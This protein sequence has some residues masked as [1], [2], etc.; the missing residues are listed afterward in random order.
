M[1][2]LSCAVLFAAGVALAGA[3]GGQA[4]TVSTS[5]E[6]ADGGMTA[7]GGDARDDVSRPADGSSGDAVPPAEA[8]VD[9]VAP[10]PVACGP[11]ACSGDA[12][13]C[14]ASAQ[15]PACAHVNCGCETQLECSRD[16]DC[17]GTTR[18]CCIDVR[19]DAA[20]AAGHFVARCAVACL[21]GAQQLCN[22]ALSRNPCLSG[23]CS[24]DSGDLQA[25]GLPAN[26]GFGVC[27]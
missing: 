6:N 24:Q 19:Q 20:C 22:P 12:P 21:M 17:S 8:S 14:C 25:V 11:T 1:Q 27:H 15:P 26:L 10:T 3:C 13:V 23:Q 18:V 9:G 7:E 2:T 5:P 16:I 4:F